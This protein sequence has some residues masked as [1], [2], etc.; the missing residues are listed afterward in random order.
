MLAAA[1][2]SIRS[3]GLA[4]PAAR[5][6]GVVLLVWLAVETLMIGWRGGPRLPL[7][8][9]CGGFGAALVGLALPSTKSI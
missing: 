5:A 2:V 6:M 8:L 9:V 3:R 4:A 1:A 7:D